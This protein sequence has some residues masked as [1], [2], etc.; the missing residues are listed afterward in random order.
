MVHL[1]FGTCLVS[2]FFLKKVEFVSKHKNETARR[3][4]LE[5]TELLFQNMN[6]YNLYMLTCELPFL[7]KGQLYLSRYTKDVKSVYGF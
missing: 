5:K 2:E 7:L 1:I 6:H 3:T 4:Y